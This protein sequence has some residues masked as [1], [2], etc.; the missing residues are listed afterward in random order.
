MPI[1][2]TGSRF[3][4]IQANAVT[5]GVPGQSSLT[6]ALTGTNNDLKF[7]SVG[8]GVGQNLVTITYVDPPGNNAALGVS[9]TGNA[10]TVNLATDG[11]SAVTSTA[12]QVAAAIAAST[13]A[14]AL[15][16]VANAAGNDGTGVV[17]ALAPTALSGGTAY[18]IG[19]PR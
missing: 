14:A 7:T 6:T 17:T 11:S 12:A 3:R 8:R 13:P 10:I 16:T 19:S 15:V 2:P 1:G 18:V 9:V 5:A 4:R